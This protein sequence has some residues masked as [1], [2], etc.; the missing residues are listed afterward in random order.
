MSYSYMCL[1]A[2]YHDQNEFNKL[3]MSKQTFLAREV[4][5]AIRRTFQLKIVKVTPSDLGTVPEIVV[6]VR[7]LIPSLF[8][9]LTCIGNIHHSRNQSQL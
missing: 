5:A 7:L 2:K 9:S 1:H 8:I 6:A 4:A 3:T